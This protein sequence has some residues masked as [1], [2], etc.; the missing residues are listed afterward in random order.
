MG[1]PQIVAPKNCSEKEG[2]VGAVS[3]DTVVGRV[4]VG[5]VCGQLSTHLSRR[6]C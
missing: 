4:C 5:R 3:I 6:C 1:G 2:G